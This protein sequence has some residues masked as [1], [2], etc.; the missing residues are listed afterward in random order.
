MASGS[1]CRVVQHCRL[2]QHCSKR[3]LQTSPVYQ[4]NIRSGIPKSTVKRNIPLTYETAQYPYQIGV[5]KSWNSWHTSNLHEEEGASE[6][7][8]EDELIRKLMRGI[9]G[10]RLMSECII[11]RRFN[12]VTLVFLANQFGK[13]GELSFLVGFTEELFSHLLKRPVNIEMQTVPENPDS[14]FKHV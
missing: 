1:L 4:K 11:K 9:W 5:T 6:A 7:A 2:V 14:S 3:C 10:R 13:M 12:T 8:M